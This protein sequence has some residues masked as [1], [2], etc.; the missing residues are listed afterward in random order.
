MASL[1]DDAILSG[2]V[3]F[4]G[5]GYADSQYV[6]VRDIDHCPGCVL[7]PL[8]PGRYCSQ[9]SVDLGSKCKVLFTSLRAPRA[10]EVE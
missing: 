5:L 3:T 7:R 1:T 8:E 9:F 6:G 2:E 4:E 10:A